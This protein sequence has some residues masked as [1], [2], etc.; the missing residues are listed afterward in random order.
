MKKRAIDTIKTS[1]GTDVSDITTEEATAIYYIFEDKEVNKIT[2]F[3]EGSDILAII[4]ESRQRSDSYETF[5]NKCLS[6]IKYNR[7]KSIETL[8][9]KIY[10]KYVNNSNQ[11]EI[12]I[13]NQYIIDLIDS[14]KYSED[15]EDVRNI[16]LEYKNKNKIN[17]DEYNYLINKL[18]DK[19][20]EILE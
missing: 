4:E 10:I 12:E 17:N 6:A 20:N 1:L 19:E 11:N 15:I 2:N 18:K 3:I 9:K 8:L 7:G 14:I 16:I 13:V 5:S